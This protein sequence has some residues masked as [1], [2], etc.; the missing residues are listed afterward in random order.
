[1]KSQLSMCSYS[2]FGEDEATCKLVSENGRSN[3]MSWVFYK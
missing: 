2:L 1:M 3:A